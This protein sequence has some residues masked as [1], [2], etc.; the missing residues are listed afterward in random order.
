MEELE[1]NS[2]EQS[3]IKNLPKS[4]LGDLKQMLKLFLMEPVSGTYALFEEKK[5]RLITSAILVGVTISLYLF[6]PLFTVGRYIGIGDALLLGIKIDV[7]LIVF[8]SFVAGATFGLKFISDKPDVKKEAFTAGMLSLPLIFFFLL[9]ATS[10]LFGNASSS[11]IRGNLS[12]GGLFMMV[13]MLYMLFMMINIVM[14]SLRAS[15]SKDVLAWYVAP[16]IILSAFYVTSKIAA[17]IL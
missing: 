7:L 16:A 8:L 14:Q 10:V 6:L 3:T 2:T 12:G 4:F 11:I 15:K 1:N 9:M 13:V 5:D 17:V